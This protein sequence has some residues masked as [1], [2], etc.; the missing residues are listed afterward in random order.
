[1]SSPS[2]VESIVEQYHP[3]DKISVGWTDE[4]GQAHTSTLTLATG[5]AD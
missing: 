2:N 1:V 4:F 3:G 5:P